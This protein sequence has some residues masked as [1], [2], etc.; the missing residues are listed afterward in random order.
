MHSQSNEWIKQNENKQF[1]NFFIDWVKH[2]IITA[3][4]VQDLVAYPELGFLDKIIGI[5]PEDTSIFL[6]IGVLNSQ[7]RYQYFPRSFKTLDD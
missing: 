1:H 6:L 4:F 5:F 7:K 2:F 3:V